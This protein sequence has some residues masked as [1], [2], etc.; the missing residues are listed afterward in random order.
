MTDWERIGRREL[1]ETAVWFLLSLCTARNIFSIINAGPLVGENLYMEITGIIANFAEAYISYYSIFEYLKHILVI[2][3]I[4]FLA[5]S[6][7]FFTI[8]TIGAPFCFVSCMI[9]LFGFI[10]Y[11]NI[12]WNKELILK[13]IVA[14]M[15]PFVVSFI[16]FI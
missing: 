5:C 13:F 2:V 8:L 14:F 15:V 4:V 9:K 6:W 16:L 10:R 3:L 12:S 1:S 11:K 7:G